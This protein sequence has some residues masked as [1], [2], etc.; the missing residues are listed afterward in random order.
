[1]RVSNQMMAENVKLNLSRISTQLVK[2]AEQIASGKRINRISDDPIGMERALDYRQQLS[3]MEQ[4]S[5]NITNAK[6]HI[7][8]VDTILETITDLLNNAQDYAS[9][10]DPSQRETFANEVGLLRDQV[11]QLANS[12]SN[13]QYLF[14]GDDSDTQPFD[15][16]TG[17]YA[18]GTGTKDFLIGEGQQVNLIA[19]G[20]DIF[21][22][23]NP[24][25]VFSVLES[26]QDEL[27]L[28]DAADSDAISS[29]MAL[30]EDAIDQ[31][32]AVRAENAGRYNRLEASENHYANFTLNVENLLSSTEDVDMASAIID[33]QVQQTAYESTLSV[34][35]QIIQKSLIDF[36]G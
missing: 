18:G 30:L 16:T 21:Q 26:L 6:L 4:Y 27:A 2:S 19:E 15:S 22:G 17:A 9:D 32:N 14:N 11:L 29:H 28:G 3:R 25:D 24:D 13:G 33:Y 1:M 31:I 10:A 36:I 7:D 34:S 12:Q 35:A 23:S 20:L 5:T 8:T